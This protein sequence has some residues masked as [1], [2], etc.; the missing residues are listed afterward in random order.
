MVA[1]ATRDPLCSIVLAHPEPKSFNAHLADLARRTLEEELT[2]IRMTIGEERYK[3]GRFELAASLF[4][5]LITQ[6]ELES[7]LTHVAYP[8]L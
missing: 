2:S 3:S 1:P 6:S 4:E 8:H 7:F 5:T